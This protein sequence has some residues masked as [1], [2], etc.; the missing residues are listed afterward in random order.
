MSRKKSIDKHILQIVEEA[1]AYHTYKDLV[2]M[3]P[4]KSTIMRKIL[5]EVPSVCSID[6]KT[7]T[8]QYP[9]EFTADL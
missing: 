6:I 8:L 1:T 2:D 3:A 5:A 4:D 9:K 7:Y